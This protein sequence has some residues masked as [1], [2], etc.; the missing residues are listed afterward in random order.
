MGTLLGAFVGGLLA[1]GVAVVVY[2]RLSGPKATGSPAPPPPP[3]DTG[4]GGPDDEPVPTT[5]ALVALNI[6]LRTAHGL[7]EETIAPVEETI[8]LLIDTVP[9]MVTRHPFETLTYELKRIAGEHLP[10]IVKEFIDLSADSRARQ[11]DTFL[12]SIGDMREQIQRANAIVAH[13]EL[14]EFKVMASFL[15]TKYASGEP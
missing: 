7:S 8:D 6:R 11:H 1:I 4:G 10:Q 12:A 2:K 5:D 3:P 14:A 15:K 9:Q 13:N